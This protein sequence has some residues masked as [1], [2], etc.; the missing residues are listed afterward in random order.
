MRIRI[1]F[2]T[3]RWGLFSTELFIF[4]ALI[5]ISYCIST[6]KF[7][8]WWLPTKPISCGDNARD[9][10]SRL[11]EYA[12][13]YDSEHN[14]AEIEQRQ[15]RSNYLNLRLEDDLDG[16]SVNK[17]ADYE[18]PYSKKKSIINLEGLPDRQKNPAVFITS[19]PTYAYS[20]Q[21]QVGANNKTPVS[22]YPDLAGSIVVYMR[23]GAKKIEIYWLDE[24]GQK[25]LNYYRLG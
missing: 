5:A 3:S 10:R 22:L 6:H 19:N 25:G 7:G 24:N 17:K 15:E 4:T 14:Y 12:F 1:L 13:N 21:P 2:K 18:N 8:I 11:E 16:N 23:K 9:L 20:Y